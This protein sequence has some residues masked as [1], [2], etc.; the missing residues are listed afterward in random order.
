[1]RVV[2][3]D[4]NVRGILYAGTETGLYISIDDGATWQR[5]QSNLP[6]TPIYDM[7]VKE[8]DLVLATHGRGFWIGEDLPLIYQM[9][10]DGPLPA[11]LAGHLAAK[12]IQVTPGPFLF[13]PRRT[14]RI[15]PDL[16]ADWMPDEGRIYGLGLGSG[17]VVLVTKTPTGQARR[18]YLDAGEG[19]TRGAVI[20]YFLLSPPE[21]DCQRDT[22]I[23][24]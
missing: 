23:P 6:A 7:R 15:L 18:V 12:V 19:A 17:A 20:D 22:G 1:M 10:I 8:T 14:Y 21:A 11:E 24:G 4:P 13:S 2:R 3:C 9:V 5:W 16:F